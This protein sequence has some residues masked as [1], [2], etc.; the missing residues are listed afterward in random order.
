VRG[1]NYY[2]ED[3]E[4]VVRTTPGID[5]PRNAAIAWSD[6]TDERI[7]VLLETTREA[8]AAQEVADTARDRV[9]RLL[10]LEAVDVIPVPRA[11][12]PFTT[13]GKVRRQAARQLAIG[14]RDPHSQGLGLVSGGEGR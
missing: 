1:Q 7:V 4:E 6:G 13:S 3:V 8:A 11:T 10:G 14:K 5:R 2:A 9:K 12:I